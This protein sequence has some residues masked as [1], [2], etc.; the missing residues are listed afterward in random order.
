MKTENTTTQSSEQPKQTEATVSMTWQDVLSQEKPKPY[1]KK[2]LAHIQQER[3]EGKHIFPP[4]KDCFN[5]FRY[6]PLAKVKV[7]ILGQDPYHGPGQAHG[8]SFSVLP[9]IKSPPSLLNI[10]KELKDDCQ[11][12]APNHGCLIAWAKQGVMLLNTALSVEAHKAQSHSDIG[13]AAFTDKVIKVINAHTT[14]TVF[15]LW[16]APAKRKVELLN[17]E[18]HLILTAPHP[19][20][21]S[22]YRGFMGCKHFSKTN[23]YLE[24]W[25]KTAINW[26]LPA[27]KSN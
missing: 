21:L 4:A 1:F 26:Q 13:W 6:T 24:K 12:T 17:T 18:R 19:S 2:I 7:V 9:G 16:G 10:Y 11:I 14:N 3:A 22:A 27:I 20:P 15:L 23:E 25:G 5:A 8:L